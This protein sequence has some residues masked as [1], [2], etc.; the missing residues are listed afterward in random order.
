M[1]RKDHLA[2]GRFLLAS[3]TAR[4]ISEN[5]FL[6][7]CFL[8]GATLPDFN[9]LTYLHGFRESRAMIGH[10]RRYSEKTVAAL[11]RKTEKANLSSPVTAFRLGTLTHYLADSFTFPHTDAF[12]GGM[13]EHRAYESLL[14]ELFALRLEVGSIPDLPVSSLEEAYA[15]YDAENPSPERDSAYISGVCLR[16]FEKICSDCRK[17]SQKA[18]D[19]SREIGYTV[20]NRRGRRVTDGQL[21]EESRRR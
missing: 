5:R 14:H 18:L 9:P 12:C 21:P 13:R 19:K 11:L 10:H 6:T 8:T 4:G 7:A 2:L 17:K 15:A 1:K 20:T 3:P 16:I